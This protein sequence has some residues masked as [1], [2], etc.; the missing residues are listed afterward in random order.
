MTTISS[1]AL[2][3]W[4]ASGCIASTLIA[5]CA[6]VDRFRAWRDSADTSYYQSF[7]TQIEFPDAA[8]EPSQEA[9]QAIDPLTLQNPS[10]LPSFDLS[11]QDAVRLA[12]ESSDV[13]RNLG[14]SVVPA[15]QGSGTEYDPALVE[16]NPL[17]GTQ[18]ALAAY[19]ATVS[20]Q[21][22]W[23]KTDPPALAG[24]GI[25]NLFI[26]GFGQTQGVYQNQIQK[27]TASGASY[28]LRSNVGYNRFDQGGSFFAGS[29]EAEWRQPMMQGSGTTF[30]LIAGP[31]APVGS[32]GGV[33]IAR[34][35]T[36]ISLA[37]F[38]AGV[39]N[40]VNDV[41]TAYWELY[42]AYRNLDALISGRESALRAW[43]QASER[44]KIGLDAR[45]S[46]A[47]ARAF[48]YQFSAQVND[49]LSGRTGLYAS[50]QNLRYMIGFTATDGRLIRPST[51]PLQAMV[52]FDWQTSLNDA[53]N[54]RVE[55]R[56]QQW[57]I[58][59]R[60]L[61]LIAARL[62]RRARLDALSQ[63]R[64]RGVGDHLTGSSEFF[65]SFGSLDFQ[66][67]RSGLEWSFPVGLRQAS[68]AFRAAQLGLAR[69]VALLE[70]QQLRISH[71]L[72]TAARQIARS[73]EQLQINYNRV[74]ADKAQVEVLEARFK[75][76]RDNIRF[77]L[78]AQQQLAQSTS[79][80]FRALVD[81]NLAVRD[82]H[83]EKGSLLTYN[84]ISL[85]E[86]AINGSMLSGAYQRGRFLTPRDNP[87][88]VQG[89]APVSRGGFD[90]STI[91]VPDASAPMTY[92]QP[93]INQP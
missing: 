74:E 50:E 71:D 70:E 10:E 37:D 5:G 54:N 4:T 25:Q 18:A 33:F 67:W 32:Y 83:Q 14:G 13:L 56:R 72:S 90:P 73:Y 51:D 77:L 68:T 24:G 21:L 1:R 75:S 52:M 62:N 69:D 3:S 61:E 55:I 12:L 36:D 64:I 41:E 80:L 19:D 9:I 42:F 30:N 38:E 93:T 58:K 81:Y 49:A 40:L 31:N 46:E 66:E 79:A 17:G 88:R 43:Q 60:E 45:D 26:L 20:S 53:I 2:R 6:P 65:D 86:D 87:E 23:Q 91:G 39:I 47:Q 82:F 78:Q 28:A 89:Q 48:Y 92:E 11:L 57:T 63:Y 8:S 59:R 84:Q 22:F 76:G 44:L 29:L 34:I 27:R 35:N 16:L 7:V 15:P 85:T